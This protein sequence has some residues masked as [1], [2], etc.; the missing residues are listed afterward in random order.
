MVSHRQ[1]KATWLYQRIDV[2]SQPVLHYAKSASG[3]L[4][5]GCI[6]K[7]QFMDELVE[8]ITD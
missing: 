4:S 5:N 3:E 2:A 6:V 8:I 7:P 1:Y